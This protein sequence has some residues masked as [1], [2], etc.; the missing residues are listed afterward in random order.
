MKIKILKP[1]V[2]IMM[3]AFSFSLLGSIFVSINVQA[4]GDDN[5]IVV[6]SMGDSYSAGEGIEPFY[7]QTNTDGSD[8]P[9]SL[10][11]HSADWFAHRSTK[12]WPSL[13]KVG[14]FNVRDYKKDISGSSISNLVR[15]NE[16]SP[17]EW[18]FVAAT[19][20]VT[21][22]F[23]NP[24][25]RGPVKTYIGGGLINPKY[26]EESNTASKLDP[27]LKVFEDNNLK[28][29]VD[30]VTMTIGGNDLG[31]SEI[32]INSV[33]Y[34]VAHNPTLMKNLIAQKR[35]LWFT[36]IK[37]KLM[38]SYQKVYNAAGSQAEIIVAGYPELYYRNAS[39]WAAGKDQ[40]KIIDDFVV[41]FCDKNNGRITEAIDECNLKF[42]NGKIHYVS[43][44]EE[45]RSNGGHGA[46]APNGNEWINGITLTGTQMI[47][48]TDIT[49]KSYPSMH[50]NEA[51]AQAYARC[52]NAKIKEIEEGKQKGTLSGK[53]CKASDRNTAISGATISVYK[54]NNLYLTEASDA[55]GNYSIELPIG[56]YYIK[57]T[58]DGYIGFNS[59]ATVV[60]DTNTYMETFLMIEGSENENGI[61]KGKIVNSLT[62]SG[63]DGVNLSVVKDWNNTSGNSEVVATAS[64]NSNGYYSLELPLGNYTVIASKD[65]YLSTSFNIIVQ[66]G[67]TDNQNGTIT[68]KVSGDEYLIT[69]TWGE[70]PKDLDSHVEGTLSNGNSFHVY[71]KHKKQN[72]GNVE[73][74]KLDYDDTTSFGPEHTTLKI[75]TDKPYYYYVYKYAGTGT[76]ANSG[77]KI[78]VH[79]GNELIGTYN[80]PTNLGNGDY[81]NV[82]AIRNGELIVKN[83]ITNNPDTSYGK[84]QNGYKT[85]YSIPND[86]VENT[87]NL[88]MVEWHPLEGL[89]STMMD[90]ASDETLIDISPKGVWS[91]SGM[92]MSEPT[93]IVSTSG[94]VL[95][96]ASFAINWISNSQQITQL[97]VTS[98]KDKTLQIDYGSSFELSK[99]GKKTTLSQL[100]ID[101]FYNYSPSIIFTADQKADEYIRNWFGFTGDGKYSMEL[102]F[103]RVLVG[104]YGYR[105][106]VENGELYQVPIVHPNSSYKVYYKE[107]GKSAVF[108]IDAAD[109]LRNI[110]IKLA[111]DE[112]KKVLDKL[113][114]NGYDINI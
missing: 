106:V 44:I 98:G 107:T 50:P 80:V 30:Y 111:D 60:Y 85:V 39:T 109:V 65:G 33:K 84:Q 91:K 61:A 82:F 29:K 23:D 76:V 36:E 105:L 56:R 1:I 41:E 21:D 9:R 55:D 93:K 77:A 54:D 11:I 63:T 3:F 42:A 52:V 68:P 10:K 67:T 48:E 108:V 17:C 102:E 112:K 12:S 62:G 38:D 6:V 15:S 5:P 114:E 95:D 100:I 24:Y 53:I 8:L 26:I 20:A 81:W 31:F 46:D 49:Q 70:N 110:R 28:N 83:T 35:K 37:Q 51:G 99:S 14:N 22:H 89:T 7:G 78:T 79:K 104:D 72:D 58:A 59:Y 47:D 86:Q 90:F 32:V 69:L 25:E 18:Y 87:K 97:K 57:I 4:Y 73:M 88:N 19:G 92:L 64:T 16:F 66:T 2:L 113:S 71:Y 101:R 74:C 96:V 40:R 27:Q 75:T 34:T 43:V 45:F 103:G 94:T 13:L